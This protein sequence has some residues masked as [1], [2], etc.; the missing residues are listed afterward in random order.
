[1]RVVTSCQGRL[2]SAGVRL[3]VTALVA[4]VA[5]FTAGL[6]E[7]PC[8][9]GGDRL[10]VPVLGGTQ[11]I[12]PCQRHHLRSHTS[13]STGG[14]S[15]SATFAAT[16]LLGAASLLAARRRV[17]PRR[18]RVVVK[19][20]QEIGTIALSIEAGKAKNPWPNVDAHSG[21]LLQ[22]Y[23]M[24]EMNYYTVLFGISRALGVCSS[25]VW[26]RALGLPLE[27]PKSMST[28][29]LKKMVGA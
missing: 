22:Y 18:G 15:L 25:L 19:A 16:T 28:D 9:G 11:E 4:G 2:S 13:Q 23:G 7:A 29:D 21:V 8:K 5:V 3:L 12:S 27:R 10:F 24:K 6:G 1:M 26:S 17:Q 20:A 14:P